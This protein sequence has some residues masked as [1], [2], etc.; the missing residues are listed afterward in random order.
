MF[1]TFLTYLFPD[2]CIGCNT[3]GIALCASCIK[4]IPLAKSPNRL[5][6]TLYSYTDPLVQK[7][8]RD[9]KYH[10]RADAAKSLLVAG[11]EHFIQYLGDVLQ[12]T[13]SERIS[14]VPIPQYTSRTRLR[15]FN[16]SR[17]LATWLKEAVQDIAIE[18]ILIKT[19]TTLPQATMDRR[20]RLHNVTDSMSAVASLD[21]H[22]LYIIIDDVMTTG[23][24]FAEAMRALRKAGAE[25]IMTLSLAHGYKNNTA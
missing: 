4:T 1:T 15:G 11:S 18:E 2:R 25:K 19:R 7:A 13:N 21:P 10:H 14:L 6:C 17:K 8:I 20:T 16:Q 22:T 23:A 9:L 24:T 12:S 5:S 3:G